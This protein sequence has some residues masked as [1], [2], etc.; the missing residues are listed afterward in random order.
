[1]GAQYGDL[2]G[3]LDKQIQLLKSIERALTC[4]TCRDNITLAGTTGP[5]PA[6]L[7][8]FVLVKTSSNSDTVVITLSDGSTY[9]LTE[10][11]ETFSDSLD[12]AGKLPEYQI[13]GAGTFKWHGI[14]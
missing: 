1:M 10:Q 8:S 7:K 6:G 11:G 3:P 14:K 4:A 13:S 9:T 12:G 2:R 5:I